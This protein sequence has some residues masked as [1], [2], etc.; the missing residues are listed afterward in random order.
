MAKASPAP[1][2]V[3]AC[4]DWGKGGSYLLDPRTGVRTLVE[5]GGQSDPQPAADAAANSESNPAVK[6]ADHA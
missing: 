4:P 2:E 6:G 3:T 1:Q 5:R